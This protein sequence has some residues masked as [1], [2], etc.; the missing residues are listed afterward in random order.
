MN[1]VV[2]G[3]YPGPGIVLGTGLTF[4]YIAART[5][6]ADLAGC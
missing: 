3:T 4:A 5:V 6:I 1:S 2:G